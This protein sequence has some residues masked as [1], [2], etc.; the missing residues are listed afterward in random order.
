MKGKTWIALISAV[1]VMG[2]IVLPVVNAQNTQ[3]MLLYANGSNGQRN[4]EKERALRKC[5]FEFLQDLPVKN[6]F[7]WYQLEYQLLW[8]LSLGNPD[9]PLR[10]VALVSAGAFAAAIAAAMT[11]QRPL[12]TFVVL[13]LAIVE[14]WT[15]TSMGLDYLLMMSTPAF[16]FAVIDNK[17]K[18]PICN[19]NVTGYVDEKGNTVFTEPFYA[20]NTGNGTYVI[21]EYHQPPGK[22]RFVIRAPGYQ[23]KEIAVEVSC[24]KPYSC[25][26]IT[27]YMDPVK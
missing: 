4:V 5:L 8:I 1:L 14:A 13:V 9:R 6:P 23:N 11:F 3:K 22:W 16:A 7:K 15:L 12:S 18:E 2:T 10:T 21:A 17:T 26:T 24:K 27:V 19:A 20:R 25:K